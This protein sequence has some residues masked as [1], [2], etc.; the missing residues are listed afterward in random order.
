MLAFGTVLKNKSYKIYNHKYSFTAAYR[1][2]PALQ[3]PPPM[4]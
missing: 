1:H 2:R 4:L 3:T